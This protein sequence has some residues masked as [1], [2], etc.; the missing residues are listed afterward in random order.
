MCLL[1]F[2]AE[3]ND[4]IFYHSLMLFT[5][6]SFFYQLDVTRLFYSVIRFDLS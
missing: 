6:Y 4:D 1:F 2:C 3:T 5:I